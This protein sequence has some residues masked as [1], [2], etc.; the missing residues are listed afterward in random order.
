VGKRLKILGLFAVTGFILGAAANLVYFK[1]LPIMIKI[2][3]QILEVTWIS[4][5]IIGA[6]LSII[7]CLAYASLPEK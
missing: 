6:F 1:A 7:G 2:F 4:W 5:G 3:P